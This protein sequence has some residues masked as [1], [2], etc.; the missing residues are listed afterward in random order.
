[1]TRLISHT[2]TS[3]LLVAI[4]LSLPPSYLLGQDKAAAKESASTPD[5]KASDEKADEKKADEKKKIATVEAKIKPIIVYESFDGVFESTRTHEV[6]TDF[7][8]WTDLKIKSVVEEGSAVSAGQ[9]LLQ[10]DT[11][12]IEKAVTEAQFAVRNSEFDL[13]NARLTMQEVESTFELDESNAERKWANA[14]EDYKYYQ[15]VQ[16]PQRMKD[17][18]YSAKT[19]GYFLEYSKDELD[20]LQ[21]MYN[22]D[23]LTEESE[24]I[25]LK[26]AQRSVESAERS[27]E[28]TMRR[29]NRDRETE[30]S[31]EKIQ[32]EDAIKRDQIS[33][34][35][36]EITLPIKKQKAEIALAQAEFSHANKVKKLNELLTDQ[37]KMALQSPADGI[38]YYGRSKRGKWVGAAGSAARRLEAEKKVAA[39]AAIM[40]I[41]DVSQMMVRA[42]LDEAKLDSLAP[43]LRGKA[44]IKSAGKTTVPA[45]IKSI[46]RIPMDDA[47][48]DCQ[49]MVENLP[50]DASV[51]PG[52]GCKLSFLVYENKNSIV[53]PKASVFSDDG[54]ISNYV[55]VVDGES[56]TRKEVTVGHTSGTDVEII[57]GLKDG[58]KIAKAKP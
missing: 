38:L 8:T 4:A 41:V 24:M 21:Q 36:S 26:R 33:H 3:L 46:S 35:R 27:M 44:Q 29:V 50:S 28:R 10:L 32:R 54:G 56:S 2:F 19:A 25:V 12:S 5:D 43:R 34:T 39:N 14:Q 40:T 16:L 23:E 9:E 17:I 45:T 30:V 13:E 52:M 53:V 55:F 49:I 31:R 18:E 37:K 57:D 48:Y 7:E 20:Q 58:D 42:N 22:E 15:T 51:M 6:E 1:M 47:K 11:E